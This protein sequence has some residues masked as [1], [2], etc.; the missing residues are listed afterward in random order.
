MQPSEEGTAYTLRRLLA[1]I[2]K[3]LDIDDPYDQENAVSLTRKIREKIIQMKGEA[4]MTI[5]KAKFTQEGFHS[6]PSAPLHKEYLA[7]RHRHLFYF[8][9]EVEVAGARTV[10]FHDLLNASQTLVWAHYGESATHCEFGENSCEEIAA[11]LLGQ[12]QNV[13]DKYFDTDGTAITWIPYIAVEVWEDDE[14]GA[15]VERD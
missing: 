6:W 4:R 5:I 12:L 1:Y 7:H 11:W 15:R 3:D 2:A 14:C 9:V 13:Y 8:Q 10:E